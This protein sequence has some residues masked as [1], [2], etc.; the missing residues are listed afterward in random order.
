[1]V[2]DYCEPSHRASISSLS[3]CCTLS[4]WT[5][6]PSSSLQLL[7]RT[8]CWSIFQSYWQIWTSRFSIILWVHILEYRI[9]KCVLSSPS[10]A[11][12][13]SNVTDWVHKFIE[14]WVTDCP[15]GLPPL[16]Q[17]KTTTCLMLRGTAVLGSLS[18]CG[19]DHWNPNSVWWNVAD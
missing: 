3:T 4:W 6:Q 5:L 7:R 14:T 15:L 19:L 12:R 2:S 18:L 9:F 13:L 11:H 1:M 17:M 8:H 10:V 16:F